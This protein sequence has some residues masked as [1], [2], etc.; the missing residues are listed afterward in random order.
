MTTSAPET[1]LPEPLPDPL[2]L[3]D[4]EPSP[5]AAG[6]RGN[7]NPRGPLT[8][9][10]LVLGSCSSLQVG[11]ALA[12]RLFPVT[13][14]AGATLLRLGLAAVALLAVTRPRVRDWTAA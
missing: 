8:A 11:A 6:P 7:G 13:G 2:A 10:L 14:A 1:A 4:A 5:A 12:R 9:L 3:G